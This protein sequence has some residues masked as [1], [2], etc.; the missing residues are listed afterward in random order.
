MFY[1]EAQKNEEGEKKRKGM[2]I[3]HIIG[4]LIYRVFI[5]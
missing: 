3:M 5:E 4:F 2:P 1:V